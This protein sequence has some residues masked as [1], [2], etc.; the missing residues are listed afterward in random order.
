MKSHGEDETKCVEPRKLFTDICPPTWV[1]HF[2]R[3]FQYEK[4]KAQ[5]A[6]SGLEETDKK[7]TGDDSK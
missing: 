5:L 2:D 7:Y 1:T 3:K 4:F 6:K